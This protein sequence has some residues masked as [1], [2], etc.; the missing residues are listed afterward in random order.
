MTIQEPFTSELDVAVSAVRRAAAAC[1]RVQETL[2]AADSIRKKD[3]SPV[4]IADFASQAIVCAALGDAFPADGIV[5][6][7]DSKA[8]RADGALRERTRRVVSEGFGHDVPDAELLDWIDRGTAGRGGS[9][10]FWT[11]DPIDG[12]K[13]FLRGQQYAVALAMLSV[14]GELLLGVLGCPNLDGTAGESGIL[15]AAVR[16]G[17]AHS[18]PA[19]AGAEARQIRVRDLSEPTQA[20]LCESVEASHSDHGTITKIASALGVSAEPLRID[21]Q[22]KYAV[23]ARG[24]ADVYLR[25]PTR[26]DYRER[27]WDHAAGAIIV[28]EAGGLVSDLRGQPLD[29]SEDSLPPACGIVAAPPAIHGDVLRA[30]QSSR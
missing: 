12:T 3:K 16:G 15:L 18:V 25:L 20:R 21:S 19:G 4:T 2:V 7:E 26:P 27:I 30:V 29:F 9:G 13:G 1:R 24:D 10:R 14:D 22:A 23:V 28:Q 17:G 5:A 8:L 11:L 6:E